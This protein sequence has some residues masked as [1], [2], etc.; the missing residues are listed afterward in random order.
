[1]TAKQ[2]AASE[3]ERNAISARRQREGVFWMAVAV[4]SYAS[5]AIFTKLI[6]AH[7]EM[8]PLD[9]ASWR[10]L[11]ATPLVWLYLWLRGRLRG[12]VPLPPRRQLLLLG[13]LYCMASVLAFFGLRQIPASIYIILFFTYPI[14]VALIGHFL[15]TGLQREG[16]LALSVTSLGVALVLAP[17]V[18][19]LH[20]ENI[21]LIGMLIALGNAWVAALYFVASNRILFRLHDPGEL[22]R[23]VAWTMLATAGIMLVIA[24]VNGLRFPQNLRQTAL[25]LGLAVFATALPIVALNIGIQRLG[26]ARS[27]IIAMLEPFLTLVLAAI[28]LAERLGGLQLFGGMVILLSVTYFEASS[29]RRAARAAAEA[30]A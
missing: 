16:W 27:A 4:T 26:A 8:Q 25:L 10:F 3:K 23:A 28:L 29:L 1:M 2:S 14:L 12:A 20:W 13:G 24:L 21:V 6:Y 15:G 9:V 17:S 5:F 7:S 22:A 30:V 19:A 18:D 11:L